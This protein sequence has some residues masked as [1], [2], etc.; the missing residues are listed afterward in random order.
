M[1]IW[2]SSS[3]G[4]EQ[5]V[6][7]TSGPRSNRNIYLQNR[8]KPLNIDMSASLENLPL[9]DAN[10]D[11]LNGQEQ[12]PFRST[13][14][15]QQPHPHRFSA[16]DTQLFVLNHP[17]SSPSQAKRAL[18]A[19]LAETERRLQE[20]SRLGTALVQQRKRLS[21]RLLDVEAQQ[22]DGEIGP[23]LRQ[24]LIDIEKEYNEVGR[25]SARVFLGP[26]TE[27]AVPRDSMHS[28]FA[29]DG[30]VSHQSYCVL[31]HL[32]GIYSVQAAH[33]SSPARLRTH[34]PSS[35]FPEICETNR[36]TK[37]ETSSLLLRSILP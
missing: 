12:D 6:R 14:R 24:K 11:R 28:P 5:V 16:F 7:E 2:L 27:G 31:L 34:R 1:L 22:T 23:E 32:I 35:K 37:W 25:A 21:E 8:A 33:R 19:H 36:P 15:A 30:K 10:T 29:L 18:E 26:K 20:T 4:L 13:P 17:S 3:V 9:Q